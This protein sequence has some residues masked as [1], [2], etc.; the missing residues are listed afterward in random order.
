MNAA[1]RSLVRLRL[2]NKNR[3]QLTLRLVISADAA[4]EV[5]A[6][7]EGR[8][9]SSEIQALRPRWPSYSGSMKLH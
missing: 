7:L 8:L 2:V 3:A 4:R 5:A 9:A 6:I 1:K